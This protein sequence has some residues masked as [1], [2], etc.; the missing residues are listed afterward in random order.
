MLAAL[1]TAEVLVMLDGIGR[2]RAH[3]LD[4]A[5][6]GRRWPFGFCAIPT[7]T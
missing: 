5:A 1:F 4:P 7:Y 3:G 2:L 6:R